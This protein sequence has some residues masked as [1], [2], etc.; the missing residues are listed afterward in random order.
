MYI[1]QCFFISIIDLKNE[2]R[3][4]L[5]KGFLCAKTHELPGAP[6]PGPPP[7]ALPLDPTGALK[8]AP[9]PHAVRLARYARSNSR[10]A[11]VINYFQISKT[12]SF[13]H[14]TGNFQILAKSLGEEHDFNS[15][16]NKN[17]QF[18]ITQVRDWT[19]TSFTHKF[20]TS[21]LKHASCQPTLTRSS[22]FKFCAWPYDF[23]NKHP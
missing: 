5:P 23:L 13:F 18:T 20:V 10:F 12:G 3:E 4:G 6:P 16:N 8:R 2:C 1:Y 11:F 14:K 21:L 7:G 22:E 19:F 17:Y 9:G 15:S